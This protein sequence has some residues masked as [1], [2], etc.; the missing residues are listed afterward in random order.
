MEPEL[1][2]ALDEFIELR[3]HADETPSRSEAIRKILRDWL[4]SEGYFRK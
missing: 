4:S 1:I 3:H 2:S